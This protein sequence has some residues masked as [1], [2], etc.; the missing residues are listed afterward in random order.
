[1]RILLIYPNNTGYNRVPIGLALISTCLLKAGHDVEVYDTTFYNIFKQTDDDIREKLFQVKESDLKSFV[2]YEQ[3]SINMIT[4]ELND[5]VAEYKPGLIGFT[6][7]EDLLEF[8]FHLAQSVR[9]SSNCP[10]V[11]GGI[12]VTMSPMDIMSKPYI[13]MLCVGEGEE[14]V[15]ELASRLEEGKS[16]TDIENIWVKNGDDIIENELRDLTHVNELPFVNLDA[17]D[18][19]HFYRP[20]EGKVYRTVMYEHSR[21]CPRVCTYCNNPTLQG[22][23]KT[24]GRYLRTKSIDRSIAE[25]NYLKSK[26][27]IELFFFIDDD[28]ILMPIDH[29][30]EL[31]ESYSKNIAV[32]FITQTYP[33]SFTEH[34]ASLLKKHG[35]ISLRMSIESGSSY[36]REKVFNR[37]S[38][39]QKIVEA[40]KFAHKYGIRITSGNIIG[41]PYETRKEI[42][43]TVYLNRECKPDDSTVNFLI[44]YKGTPIRKLCEDLGYI[45]DID[46]IKEGLRGEPVLN[47]PQI[48][49]EQLKGIQKTFPFYCQLPMWSF[50][51]IRIAEGNSYISK[52][53]YAALALWFKNIRA[54]SSL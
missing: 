23:Y 27:G 15:V 13:D 48:S 52:V 17:F 10:I 44:P 14:A 54:T 41:N 40:F 18:D 29:L 38:K 37:R 53:F 12:A 7:N 47:M 20:L 1:M 8:A 11:F 46:V 26:Y 33:D 43:E 35:C 30:N 22:L 45:N 51:L 21:G 34:K 2:T 49:K 36:I 25:L 24:K 6:T 3:K 4:K 5:L 9:E 19:R 50:F 16:I 42:M 32:P 39:K 28:F 31:L